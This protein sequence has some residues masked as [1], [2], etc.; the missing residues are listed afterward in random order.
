[1][2][3]VI[4]NIGYFSLRISHLKTGEVSDFHGNGS[5]RFLHQGWLLKQKRLDSQSMNTT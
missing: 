2:C 5:L 1:L 3:V 4:P